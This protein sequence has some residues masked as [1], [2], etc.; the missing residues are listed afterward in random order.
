MDCIIDTTGLPELMPLTLRRHARP[1]LN[2]LILTGSQL[3]GTSDSSTSPPDF[4]LNPGF[5]LRCSPSHMFTVPYSEAANER[6]ASSN[7]ITSD[8]SSREKRRLLSVVRLLKR[9]LQLLSCRRPDH[10][11]HPHQS[12]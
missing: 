10:I 11:D 6:C 8:C 5:D 2:I 12:K 9:S 1:F 3:A 7:A 4:P